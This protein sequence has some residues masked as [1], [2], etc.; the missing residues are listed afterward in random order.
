MKNI[1]LLV[2]A[3]IAAGYLLCE[4]QNMGKPKIKL[5]P[6]TENSANG[7]ATLNFE[8]NGEK[9]EVILT[10]D[11]VS[12]APGSKGEITWNVDMNSLK[13]ITISA[14]NEKTKKASAVFTVLPT[15]MSLVKTK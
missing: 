14:Y 11:G 9:Q 15:G 7:L 12:G 5:L 6:F 4:A 10:K 1:V 2:G 13:N 8:I 3:G